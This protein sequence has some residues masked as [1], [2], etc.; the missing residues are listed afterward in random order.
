M[1][2]LNSMY[3]MNS[4]ENFFGDSNGYVPTSGVVLDVPDSHSIATGKGSGMDCNHHFALL[5]FAAVG[6]LY[7]THHVGFRGVN[8]T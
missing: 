6:I 4:P 1:A 8:V 5:I 7:L 2:D 3:N